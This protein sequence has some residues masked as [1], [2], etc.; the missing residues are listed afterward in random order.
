MGTLSV[1]ATFIVFAGGPVAGTRAYARSDNGYTYYQRLTGDDSDTEKSR[2]NTLY[3]KSKNYVYG[4][5]PAPF[6]VQ[7]LA[8]LPVGR[9]LDVAMGE[10]RNSVFLAKK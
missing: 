3:S 7:N 1:L 5:E 10:G 9:A 8:L 6:L 4:R 2:W